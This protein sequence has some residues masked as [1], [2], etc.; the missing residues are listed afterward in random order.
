[1]TL[2]RD[3]IHVPE[4]VHAGDFVLKLTEG[5]ENPRA[6]LSSYVVTEQLARCFDEALTL[7][8]SSIG[9]KQSKGAYLHGSFGS[10]KSHFMAVLHLLLTGD[11]DARGIS[12]LAEV[13]HKHS[14]WMAGRK[15]LLVPCHMIGAETLEQRVLGGYAERVRRLHPTAPTPGV[16]LEES[17]FENARALRVSMEDQSFF[18]ALNAA[19]EAESNGWG[20][21]D[22][23]WDAERFDR[24]LAESPGSENR[25]RLVGDLVD[26]LLPSLSGIAASTGQKYADIDSGLAAIS[27]HARDLGYDGL[28]IFLDEL[29]LWLASKSA[30]SQ[31]LQR[32]GQKISKLVEA[33]RADR[34]VPIVSFVA[35]QRDLRELIGESFPGFQQL[36]FGDVLKWWEARFST[37][38]LEDRNLP[39]I[40][41]RRVLRPV[42]DAARSAID[43]AFETTTKVRAE[44]LEILLTSRGDRETFRRL[45]PFSPALVDALVALSSMLQRDRTAIKI[46]MQMLVKRRESLTLGDIVP[47]G[48]LFDALGSGGDAYHDSLKAHFES[49]TKLWETKLRPMLERH[50]G[51]L[52]LDEAWAG[53]ADDQKARALVND[54]RIVKTLLVAAL[55]PN[56]ECLKDL[57]GTKL[58]ALNHGTVASPIPN[59]EG[60]T[61]LTKCRSWAAEAGEIRISDDPHN[62]TIA[63]KLVGVDTGPILDHA[64]AVDNFGN[65]VQKIRDLLF[66]EFGVEDDR[67]LSYRRVVSWRGTKREFEVV[68][69]NVRELPDESMR[70][71]SGAEGR[72][73][74]DF[75]FDEMGHEASEDLRRIANFVATN[76]AA[77][78][79]ILWVPAYLTQRARQDLGRLVII[80]HL[81]R[82]DNL[83]RATENLSEQDRQQARISL[84]SQ[85]SS[86]KEKIKQ[87]LVGAYGVAEP[88]PD[89]V[90][91]T[92]DKSE[93]LQ[94]LDPGFKPRPP[95]GGGLRQAFEAV[96]MQLLEHRYPAHPDFSGSTA[97]TLSNLRKARELMAE[98]AQDSDRRVAVEIN[99][100]AFMRSIA[101]NLGLGQIGDTHFV[102]DGPLLDSL[103]GKVGQAPSAPTVRQL[104]EWLD[105]PRPRGLPREVADLVILTF[106]D[107]TSRFFRLRGANVAPDIGQLHDEATLHSADLPGEDEWRSALENAGHVFGI[108]GRLFRSA[109]NLQSLAKQIQD[110]AALQRVHAAELVTALR[111]ALQHLRQGAVPSTRLATAVAVDGLLRGVAVGSPKDVVEQV[112][113]LQAPTNS[114]AMGVS[115]RKSEE[116]KRALNDVRWSFFDALATLDTSQSRAVLE[117][118]ED[119]L[120]KDEIAV[121]L[122]ERIRSLESAAAQ[123]LVQAPATRPAPVAPPSAVDPP[124]HVRSL[125]VVE[126]GSDEALDADGLQERVGEIARIV[127]ERPLRR[128]SLNWAITEPDEREPR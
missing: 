49:A 114:S 105:E 21:L 87:A 110:A 69:A 107:A 70:V 109:S 78:P 75:P 100:R 12:E 4:T 23:P 88:P 27:R 46:M 123:L 91:D 126:Q 62:P 103:Q 5:V 116:V 35:R 66:A 47:V 90:D 128:V 40:I 42:S 122:A 26:T 99:A 124:P 85:S 118:L 81:L 34:P 45:Y 80:D 121:G 7:V 2:I 61:V 111:D 8:Q 51:D 92:P 104:R 77:E 50:H 74:V 93:R 14:S 31:F 19:R 58:A 17:V 95:A 84:E 119:A 39:T 3:L 29:M 22:A 10:G 64:K 96:L 108:T 120:T 56:I 16:F 82:G 33:Q 13:V 20:G 97:L 72:I 53:Q 37:I 55:V 54:A 36:T 65:R 71:T 102:L 94:S 68:F 44:I 89:M 106:A 60:Q 41:E 76:T 32:E 15:F 48:D 113:R 73:I 9:E 125:R 18:R 30:D 63:I 28:V 112:A 1:M 127:R 98:A 52:D 83:N 43:V 67:S 101:V 6:T 38:T 59:R 79:T 25:Q 86:L 24:V 11:A 117:G 57:T 115:F